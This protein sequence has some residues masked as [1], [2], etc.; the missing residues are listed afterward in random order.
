MAGF[1]VRGSSGLAWLPLQKQAAMSSSHTPVHTPV[2]LGPRTAS[3][4]DAGCPLGCLP[5]LHSHR[6]PWNEVQTPW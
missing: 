5:E 6:I 1:P 4:H 3:L 2:A